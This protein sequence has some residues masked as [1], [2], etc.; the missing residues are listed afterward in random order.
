MTAVDVDTPPVTYSI[1]G[2]NDGSAFAIDPASGQITTGFVDAAQ[3]A[4]YTLEVE[5]TDAAGGG[6]LVNAS[7]GVTY[8]SDNPETFAAAA[9]E[10]A[11][12]LR[13]AINA[14]R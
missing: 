6:I 14:A 13:D 3:Q 8:A 11:G 1:M 7:R 4:E 9:R 12:T 2:G 5:A 10:A